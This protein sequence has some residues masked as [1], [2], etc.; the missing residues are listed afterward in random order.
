MTG[1]LSEPGEEQS[2]SA[3]S[4]AAFALTFSCADVRWAAAGLPAE[5]EWGG[6]AAQPHQQSR[7][8]LP[9]RPPP[10]W[11][12]H[13]LLVLQEGEQVREVG[14]V[15]QKEG[16]LWWGGDCLHIC[17]EELSPVGKGFQIKP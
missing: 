3:G 11:V 8:L 1:S 15:G 7:R 17:W 4:Q 6:C 9:V 13:G 16:N 10:H 2:F 5:W 14:E 12:P